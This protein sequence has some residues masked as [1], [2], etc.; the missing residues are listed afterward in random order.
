LTYVLDSRVKVKFHVTTYILLL[1]D[2]R[3]IFY[4]ITR[5]ALKIF[6]L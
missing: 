5:I 1:C 2:G 6:E 4:L 3:V